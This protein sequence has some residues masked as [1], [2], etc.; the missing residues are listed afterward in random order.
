LAYSRVVPFYDLGTLQA[1]LDPV[2]RQQGAK[3]TI[4]SLRSKTYLDWVR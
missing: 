1:K 3:V 2:R 4:F